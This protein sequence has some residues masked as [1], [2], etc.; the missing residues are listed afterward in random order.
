MFAMSLPVFSPRIPLGTFSIL[1]ENVYPT[2]EKG[3]VIAKPQQRGTA[4]NIKQDLKVSN[5]K[6]MSMQY[7]S[8]PE[9]EPQQSK[10]MNPDW[11]V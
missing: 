3:E 6:K 8:L 1:R 2:W 7:D 4:V 9:G 10:E 5:E 11:Q